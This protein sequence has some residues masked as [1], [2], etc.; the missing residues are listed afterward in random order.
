MDDNLVIAP[1][2][3]VSPLGLGHKAATA[4]DNVTEIGVREVS[5]VATHRQVARRGTQLPRVVSGDTYIHIYIHT[6]YLTKGKKERRETMLNSPP[7]FV[8]P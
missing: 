6:L 4:N 8:R 3:R 7:Q 5:V 1:S 2:E